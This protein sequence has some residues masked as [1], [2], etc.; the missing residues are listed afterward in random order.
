MFALSRPKGMR[1]L[2]GN[3]FYAYQGLFEKAAEIAMYY[4]FKPISTP[5]IEQ[6]GV[7]TS[8]IGA[9]TDIVKKE[10]YSIKS[11]K[12]NGLVLRPEGTAPIMRS[13][14]ENGMHTEPQPVML[15]YW[16]PF[17]RHE[18]PQRGRFREFFQFGLEILGSTQSVGDALI[19]RVMTLILNEAGFKNCM[20]LINSIGCKDCRLHYMKTLVAYYKKRVASLCSDCKD[21]LRR[22]PLRLLDCKDKRCVVIKSGAPETVAYLCEACRTHFKEVL[23]YLEAQKI[24]Y[25]IDNTLVRGIDYYTKT[26]FEIINEENE[27]IPVIPKISKTEEAAPIEEEQKMEA[28][29]DTA[30]KEPDPEEGAPLPLALAGGGRYDY[31]AKVLG[32]RR[33]IPSVGGALGVDRVIASPSFKH[34]LPRIIKKPKIYFIQIGFEAKAKSL[35]AIEILR[36]NKIP[37]TH[38]LSKD[39]LSIQL[40]LAEKSKIPF[41]II[42]GQR[43]ALE[44]TVIVRQMSTR[45]QDTVKVEKLGEYLKK[46]L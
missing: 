14:I 24:P 26:V 21:R 27:E 18:R 19:I 43:E 42:L 38:A 40:A 44:D 7:F 28:E 30:K 45:S 20:T 35:A 31:L 39:K 23:E 34:L 12:K 16:G 17:W 36:K 6:E 11:R 2:I 10:M 29:N 15:Y 32:S 33:D 1:D 22:N 4:G 25:R 46:K 13:Y 37:I 9:D 8:G 3:D 41:V 5:A